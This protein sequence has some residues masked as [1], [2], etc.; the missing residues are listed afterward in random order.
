[1]YLFTSKFTQTDTEP[2]I[3]PSIRPGHFLHA[4]QV[5]TTATTQNN[6]STTTTR[7]RS[8]KQLPSHRKLR[9]WNNDRFI[10]THSKGSS[11]AIPPVVMEGEE[12]WYQEYWMPNYPREY[13]SEFA[14]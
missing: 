3:Q 14:R 11:L 10:G 5:R 1:V 12:E 2:I 7:H 6:Q 9:R 8:T 4:H 13:R